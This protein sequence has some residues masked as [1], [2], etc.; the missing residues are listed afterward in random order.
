MSTKETAVLDD[1][2]GALLLC[3]VI[4]KILNNGLKGESL[5]RLVMLLFVS[6]LSITFYKMWH[7]LERQLYGISLSIWP[8]ASLVPQVSFEQTVVWSVNMLTCCLDVIGDARDCNKSPIGRGRAFIR[9][10]LNEGAI[11]DYLKA[12]VWNLELAR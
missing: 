4:E 8:N 2:P 1:T 3:W 9:I 11:C 6:S 10:A 5:H 12:L 7:C